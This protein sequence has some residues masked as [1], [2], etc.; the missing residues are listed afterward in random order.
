[1]LLG[2]LDQL[3]HPDFPALTLSI[4]NYSK[5]DTG[6]THWWTTAERQLD[7]KHWDVTAELTMQYVHR[8]LGM[9]GR[10]I[11]PWHLQKK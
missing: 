8:Q 4:F 2:K 6:Y 11:L 3:K 1:M 10:K 5:K 9:E 7:C